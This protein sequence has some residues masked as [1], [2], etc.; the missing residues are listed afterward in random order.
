[1]TEEIKYLRDN[2]A[3]EWVAM[4]G[5]Y[6]KSSGNKDNIFILNVTSCKDFLDVG[7]RTGS[8]VF[9]DSELPFE[10]NAVSC[11]VKMDKETLQ[12]QFKLSRTMLTDYTYV[13]QLVLIVTPVRGSK[14]GY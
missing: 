5:R 2:N 4:S 8:D 7:I 9:F 3:S 14:Y 11:F 12:P 1:M 6:I 10:E 13:G